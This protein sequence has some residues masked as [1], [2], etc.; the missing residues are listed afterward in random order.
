[1]NS[2][3]ILYDDGPMLAVTKP[4]GLSTQAPSDADSLERRLRTQLSTRTQY[5]AFPHRLDR[6]VSGVILVALT[7]RAA[8]LLSDQF[9]SRKIS[10][11]YLAW[12]TGEYPQA[13]QQTET[14]WR[15]SIR[16]IPD[17]ARGEVCQAAGTAGEEVRS[18]SSDNNGLAGARHAETQV[19]TVRYDPIKQR[20]L[21]Q[22]CPV[23]G[24]MHQLRIQS[25]ARGFP[26]EGDALYG[27]G[28][29]GSETK[30][31]RIMLH[32]HAIEFHDPKNGRKQRVECPND[33]F[34]VTV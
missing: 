17:E 22:L 7:K 19:Q 5:V 21:L 4:A 8:R 3:E 18:D 31:Q 29:D 16:K 23:T 20:T 10:K 12:V 26:I 14:I 33:D 32:A 9:A 34:R 11:T 2:I 6:P 27:S 30:S 28:L 1:M 13:G 24:R 15:D 25:S